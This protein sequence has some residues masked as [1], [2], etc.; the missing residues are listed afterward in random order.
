VAQ[1]LEFP[2]VGF[3][4]GHDLR[5]VKSNPASGSELGLEPA[6]DSPSPSTPPPPPRVHMH[7]FSLA[8]KRR[9]KILKKKKKSG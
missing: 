9:N 4:S 6:S 3:G 5:V 7:V 1:S 8:L 2:T